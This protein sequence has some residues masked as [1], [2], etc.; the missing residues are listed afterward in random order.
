M[1]EKQAAEVAGDECRTRA[2]DASVVGSPSSRLQHRPSHSDVCR[3]CVVTSGTSRSP[4]YMPRIVSASRLRTS[5]ALCSRSSLDSFRPFGDAAGCALVS[6]RRIN[7]RATLARG[8]TCAD[9]NRISGRIFTICRRRSQPRCTRARTTTRRAPGGTTPACA[10]RSHACTDRAFVNQALLPPSDR[11]LR[12][13]CEQLTRWLITVVSDVLFWQLRWTI[14]AMARVLGYRHYE[15]IPG[16]VVLCCHTNGM[17]HV[18]QMLRILDVLNAS[19][20]KVGLVVLAEWSRVE[21]AAE[22]AK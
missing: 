16:S 11:G 7:I 21:E 15:P 1:A 4:S 13:F 14:W 17:G 9:A 12:S 5:R 18:I 8:C 2:G 6:A 19:S 3:A 22:G 10:A 20:I